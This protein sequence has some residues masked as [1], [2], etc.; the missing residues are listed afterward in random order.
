MG[1]IGSG[2]KR[3]GKR[4]TAEEVQRVD[5]IEHGAGVIMRETPTGG[6]R[7]LGKCE[8][9]G[10]GVRWLYIV[11]NATACERCQKLTRASRQLSGTARGELRKD[12]ALLG[13]ALH[14]AG[15]Y[16]DSIESGQADENTLRE[17][18]RIIE[19]AAAMPLP[20]ATKTTEAHM[21]TPSN[22]LTSEIISGATVP[23]DASLQMRVVA[24]DVAK[25]TFLLEKIEKLIE[26]GT[27]NYIN[28]FGEISRVPLRN[29]SFCKLLHAYIALSNARAARSGVATQ[30]IENR[31][32]SSVSAL[33]EALRRAMTGHHDRDGFSI[34]DLEAIAEVKPFRPST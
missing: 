21:I 31:S 28:R 23:A 12:P 22:A 9:C 1:G 5:A 25:T 15:A 13:Q 24:S 16:L 3:S 34:E 27:E 11:G 4:L 19:A 7:R 17:A 14:G 6:A 26:E 2:W 29:D 20:A 30:I 10:R 33:T 8:K 32:E 18:M